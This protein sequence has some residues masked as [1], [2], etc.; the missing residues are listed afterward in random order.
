MSI[1]GHR[2]LLGAVGVPGP[3]SLLTVCPGVGGYVH[4]VGMFRRVWF[5]QGWV[6]AGE[7]SGYVY[8]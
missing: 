5:V 2:P 8:R 1:P 6:C 4:R 3:R 7:G